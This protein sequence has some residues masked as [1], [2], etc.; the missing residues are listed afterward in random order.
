MGK[1]W[2]SIL[3]GYTRKFNKDGCVIIPNY[4]LMKRFI[5]TSTFHVKK[6]ISTLKH[7]IFNAEYKFIIQ[8]ILIIKYIDQ[9]RIYEGTNIED[10]LK[11]RPKETCLRSVREIIF[12]PQC[13]LQERIE[14]LEWYGR[15]GALYDW[16]YFNKEYLISRIPCSVDPPT[17]LHHMPVIHP[18]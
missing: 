18:S 6:N 9:G 2:D 5:A 1:P 8:P 10:F 15:W 16:W 7:K 12:N 3:L 17:D 13:T 11:S 4:K 14:S